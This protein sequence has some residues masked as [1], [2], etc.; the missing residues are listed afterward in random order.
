MTVG[1]KE[2]NLAVIDLLSGCCHAYRAS[3]RSDSFAT[4]FCNDV[5][6]K[7]SLCAL[8]TENPDQ[9]EQL[10][11]GDV[12]FRS[13]QTKHGQID[14]D[15]ASRFSIFSSDNSR[16]VGA[17]PG[18]TLNGNPSCIHSGWHNGSFHWEVQKI[19][20]SHDG[21]DRYLAAYNLRPHPDQLPN[22]PD[23]TSIPSTTRKWVP[24]L[25]DYRVNHSEHGCLEDIQCIQVHQYLQKNYYSTE[26]SGK[27]SD[28]GLVVVVE[29]GLRQSSSWRI[30]KRVVD[31]PGSCCRG[32]V[33]VIEV[34][35]LVQVVAIPRLLSLRQDVVVIVQSR[36]S[37]RSRSSIVQI[38]AV[39]LVQVE[40]IIL[41]QV[42]VVI[43]EVVSMQVVVVLRQ[44]V[45]QAVVVL[46]QAVRQ[47][48]TSV[49]CWGRV[50]DGGKRRGTIQRMKRK[51]PRADTLSQP[52]AHKAL[53]KV[54]LAL[55]GPMLGWS[56]VVVGAPNLMGLTLLVNTRTMSK[57]E[58]VPCNAA[59]PQTGQH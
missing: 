40:V 6:K 5:N 44:V 46:P 32:V 34:I 38:E 13:S 24:S 33:V 36:S 50:G 58:H 15:H 29:R 57:N 20:D 8:N 30:I 10:K 17:T 55:S 54:G 14:H 2:I 56:V 59:H 7:K 21:L 39:I 22:S 52:W 25:E 53:L 41:V 45:A 3:L 37:W 47:P 12:I 42:A 18:A 27:Q 4:S 9:A 49:N 16:L 26:A 28:V 43:P 19:V 31:T 51:R 1:G 23:Y 11:Q 35:I 48:Y